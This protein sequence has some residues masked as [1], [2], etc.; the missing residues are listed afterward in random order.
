MYTYIHMY[1]L[2]IYSEAVISASIILPPL[3]NGCKEIED[4]NQPLL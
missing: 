2:Y 3:H 4:Q 1:I